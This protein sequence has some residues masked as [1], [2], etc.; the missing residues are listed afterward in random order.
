MG[1]YT[2]YQGVG[3]CAFI[4]IDL[5]ACINHANQYCDGTVPEGY[6]SFAPGY[7]EG[8]VDLMLTVLEDIFGLPSSGAGKGGTTKAP[9]KTAF[10]W[11]LHQ[12]SPNPVESHTAVHYEI[13]R[14]CNV[15][16]KV[17]NAQGQM[18]RSLVEERKSPGRYSAYWDGSNSAGDKVS[19]GVYFCRMEA[20]DFSSVKKML[21]VR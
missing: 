11:A 3:Q 16:L 4:N 20:A 8:R 17:Y 9:D 13:A 7:Y 1:I 18:V 19:S 21:V 10:M 5:S 15:R 12:N 6:Q 2:E 14:T